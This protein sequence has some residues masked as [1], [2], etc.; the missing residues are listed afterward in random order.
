MKESQ[1]TPKVHYPRIP[2]DTRLMA[3]M[4]IKIKEMPK[5]ILGYN[6]IL[7][8]VCEYTNW[9]KAIPLADQKAG[10]IADVIK[11]TFRF[12]IYYNC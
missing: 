4:S 3:R 10:T 7:V 8:C 5:S 9:I 11:F 2:I 12:N 6:C 1:P